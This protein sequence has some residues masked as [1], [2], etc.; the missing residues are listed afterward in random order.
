MQERQYGE[1]SI[2]INGIILSLLYRNSPDTLKFILI[3]SSRDDF[4][5]Y[6]ALPH[7]F[8]PI[9]TKSNDAILSSR[10]IVS[11]M[12]RRER[13]LTEHKIK[14]IDSYNR[15]MRRV[16]GEEIPYIVIIVGELLS[17]WS[18]QVVMWRSYS[19]LTDS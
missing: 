10:V 1:K 11:E 15:K 9:V 6:N 16:G 7:L 3:N 4:S 13:I 19:K 5:A 14:S 12:E 17:L 18:Y 2:G 8:L